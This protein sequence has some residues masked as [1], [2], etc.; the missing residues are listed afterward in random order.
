M[1]AMT[2][3]IIIQEIPPKD[4]IGSIYIPE[5]YRK[6]LQQGRI[7][8]RGRKIPDAF[9]VGQRVFYGKSHGKIFHYE[10]EDYRVLKPESVH[11]FINKVSGDCLPLTPGQG[12]LIIE[13]DEMEANASRE[14]DIIIPETMLQKSW[15]GKVLAVAGDVREDVEP[16]DVVY[17]NRISGVDITCE[18]KALR[19]VFAKDCY[20]RFPRES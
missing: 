14:A 20:Y 13:P 10:G 16:G 11:L 8:S 19:V 12:R 7:T 5:K 18:G 1:Q 2:D 15:T 6:A 3:E 4:R 9:A 17:Y